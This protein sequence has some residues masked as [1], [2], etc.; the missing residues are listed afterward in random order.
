ML[1][2]L[3]ALTLTARAQDDPHFDAHGMR[4]APG[5]NRPTD[6]LVTWRPDVGRAGSFAGTVLV[7]Y[8]DQTLVQVTEIDGVVT[9]EP[10]M[11]DLVGVTALFR[12]SLHE[13]VGVAVEAPLALTS[14]QLGQS[15]PV[16]LRD[17]RVA[18]PLEILDRDGL[19]VGLVPFVDLPTGS[20]ER[21]L[22]SGFGAGGRAALSK[23]FGRLDVA[24][25]LGA[26]IHPGTTLV[27]LTGGPRLL[28][29]LSGAVRATDTLA[30]QLELDARGGAQSGAPSALDLPA[31]AVASGRWVPPVGPSVVLGGATT[32]TRGAGSARLRLFLGVSL[33]LDQGR[34]FDGDGIADKD[35]DCVSEAEVVNGW[36]DG[37]G[38][39]DMLARHTIRVT[40]PEGEPMAGVEI[41][42]GDTVLGTTDASGELVLVDAMP[43]ESLQIAAVPPEGAKV[44]TPDPVAVTLAEGP[45]DTQ[46]AFTWRPGTFKL[47]VVDEDGNPV[48]AEITFRGASELPPVQVSG[49]A[50]LELP[51]GKWSLVIDSADHGLA[52]QEIVFTGKAEETLQEVTFSLKA[53]EV[54]ATREEVVVLQAV[55]FQKESDALDPA[56]EA[57]LDEVAANLLKYDQLRRIE[58]QGHTSTDGPA[59][60]NLQLSQR[61][62]ENVVQY[63]VGRGVAANRVVAVGYGE[64]CPL[65]PDDTEAN[66]ALNRRVQFIVLDPA[67]AGGVPCHDGNPARR[68][69]PTTI[70]I[71]P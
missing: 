27:N 38:C 71:D 17:I 50:V 33:G 23:S 6:G 3:A 51:P 48:D 22:S 29:G 64:A 55:R 18:V 65:A 19:V 68:A 60:F 7:D 42:D 43:G 25:N 58:V 70:S 46:I 67:P 31:E 5:L 61:R 10:L 9:E 26:S 36:A 8:A 62:M 14:K 54:A 28:G 69:E 15:Q 32:L 45:S 16:S 1:A 35:D 52:S 53:R 21:L 4:F 11:Q 39:P 47:M 24:A 12:A 49:E 63:L 56:S 30:F 20:A 34:D 57:L 59:D 44:R 37:D 13:R 2:F 40:G 66:R 41:R